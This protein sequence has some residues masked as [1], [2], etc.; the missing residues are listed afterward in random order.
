MPIPI[1]N[2]IS[3]NTEQEHLLENLQAS[4]TSS[5]AIYMLLFTGLPLIVIVPFIWYLFSSTTKSMALLCLLSIT[6]L[7]S[8]AYI[9]YMIPLGTPLGSLST[10]PRTAPGAQQR[11][12]HGGSQTSF[13]LTSDESPINQYLPYLNAFISALLFLGSWAYRSR[14]GTPDGFWIFLLFP[15]V[16]FMMVFIARRTMADVQS[17]LSELRGMRYGYKGA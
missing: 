16:I 1:A 13:L 15:G 11:R 17:G 8:S 4:E 9:M 5:N 14:T 6:S 3:P 7:V 12:N 2:Y 10:F